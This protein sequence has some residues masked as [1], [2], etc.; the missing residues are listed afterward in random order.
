MQQQE[1]ELEPPKH[2]HWFQQ[3]QTQA[4]QQWRRALVLG[5]VQAQS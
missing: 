3:L 5:Q 4:Q 1:K 2:R